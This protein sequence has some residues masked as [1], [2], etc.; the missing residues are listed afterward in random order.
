M[1]L[2]PPERSA[3]ETP[4]EPVEETGPRCRSIKDDGWD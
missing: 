3:D 1:P 2:P 4:E